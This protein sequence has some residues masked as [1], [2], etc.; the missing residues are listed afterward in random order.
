M[1]GSEDSSMSNTSFLTSKTP[2]A[3]ESNI[4]SYL[5]IIFTRSGI[6]EEFITE[7]RVT[8]LGAWWFKS[9]LLDIWIQVGGEGWKGWLRV[10]DQYETRK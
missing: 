9:E 7:Q 10:K 8:S 5:Q 2:S 4:N 6:V 1:P 3:K